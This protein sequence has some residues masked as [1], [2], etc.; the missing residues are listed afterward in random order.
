MVA[1]N[2]ALWLGTTH[3]NA[4]KWR[5]E[6]NK[7]EPCM[8]YWE[9]FQDFEFSNETLMVVGGLLVL[10]A[11]LQ[12]IKSSMKLAFWVLLAA[13]GGWGALY[14]YDRSS[15]RLP[16]NLAEEARN[17]AGPGGLT[18]GM[19]QALCL[20]V[21]TEENA[22]AEPW[23]FAPEGHSQARWPSTQGLWVE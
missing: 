13:L 9:A 20:K 21:L 19:M 2:L 22:S 15:V 18:E 3:Q 14:G 5:F 17:L 10:V 4:V 6:N 23:L 1:I 16:E 12:I 8:E 7:A 11:I